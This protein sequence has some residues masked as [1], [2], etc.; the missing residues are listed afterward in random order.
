LLREPRNLA[1]AYQGGCALF[2]HLGR[3][4]YEGHMFAQPGHR[5]RAALEFGRL[6]VRWL[7]A[8]A[9]AERLSVFAPRQLP[10]VSFYCRR[11]G[12]ELLGRDLFQEHFQLEASRWAVL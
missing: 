2:E 11:L 3:G 4:S 12:M 6:A 7:F 10:Q 8:E 9:K 1:L 5:G